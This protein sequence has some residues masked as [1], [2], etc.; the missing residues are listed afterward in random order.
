MRKN[1]AW[2]RV[3]ANFGMLFSSIAVFA[4]SASKAYAGCNSGLG[5]LDPTCPGRILNPGDRV[6]DAGAGAYQAAAEWMQANNG[7]SQSLDAT[8]K[9]YLRPHFGDLVDRVS[10]IYNANL[11]DEWSALGYGIDLGE[12]AAQTYCDRI[13]VDDPYQESDFNQIILLAHEMTHSKQCEDYGGAGGFGWH[14][15]KEYYE[16]G[17]D[18]AS[19]RLEREAFDFETQ[20]AGWLEERIARDA[21][22]R[23]NSGRF[24]SGF[25]SRVGM[26]PPGIIYLWPSPWDDGRTDVWCNVPNHSMYARHI[27]DIGSAMEIDDLATVQN[28]A[29]YWSQACSDDVFQQSRVQ[30]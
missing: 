27:N 8:Q 10:V 24:R 18:Y 4:L 12:S 14:Y 21:N 17:A 28:S 25:Y 7:S 9:Q 30:N 11:M 22:H 3:A 15:F 13:Y 2:F 19:N 6:G 1:K 23:T 20:F 16:G 26:N 5:R 29:E